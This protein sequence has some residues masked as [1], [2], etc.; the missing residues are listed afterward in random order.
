[1]ID[2]AQIN[3]AKFCICEKGE[4]STNRVFD[5]ILTEA[6]IYA[7]FELNFYL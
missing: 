4:I 6:K 5:S 2:I 1:M 3:F 7:E